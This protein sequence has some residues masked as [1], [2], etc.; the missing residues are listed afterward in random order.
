MICRICNQ[1][2]HP[3]EFGNNKR[4]P[5]GKNNFCRCCKKNIDKKSYSKRKDKIIKQKIDKVSKTRYEVDSFK[6]E[7]IKCGET[8]KYMLDF[9]HIDSNEKEFHISNEIWNKNINAIKN[10][11]KK[12][13]ILCSNH[14][15]EYHH[16]NKTNGTTLEEYLT[17]P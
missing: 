7:C 13:V 2:K 1:D 15:R 9:H 3:D 14:H 4:K 11:I 10:E 12:C 6:T 8:K 16:L 5:N 17:L